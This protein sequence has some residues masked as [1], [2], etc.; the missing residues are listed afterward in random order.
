M[1]AVSCRC[2][3]LRRAHQRATERSFARPPSSIDCRMGRPG[4]TM[5]GT[6]RHRRCTAR[7]CLV[8]T[9]RDGCDGSRDHRQARG[10]AGVRWVSRVCARRRA[11]VVARGRCGDRQDR[12]LAGGQSARTRARLSRPDGALDPFG[13]TDRVRDG[14][15]SVR[16]GGGGD[17]AAVD[18]GST[19]RARD[20][21]ADAGAGR[22]ATG[23]APARAR[24]ALGRARA[25]SEER[26]FFS[27]STMCSGS[28]RARRE[29]LTFVLRRLEGEP[30]GVLAT[31][32][33]RPVEAPLE[34]DRAFGA[35]RRLAVEPLSVGAI[36][37][38]LWGRLALNLPRPVL[39]R[40]HEITGWKPV[41]RARARAR[42]CRGVR[43]A[44]TAGASRCPRA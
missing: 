18:A 17:A 41:L 5:R 21:V 12:A 25:C 42:A 27:R 35:F 44:R 23:G 40:V 31:V 32:R 28:M 20:R 13:D 24:A 30:V 43:S 38:L 2:A 4:S 36:H 39:V 16:A 3:T 19:A 14:R 26:R 29:V 22:A 1:P 15:R 8:V 7:L 34:L 33:G 37:R 10:T 6:D 11:R 9:R